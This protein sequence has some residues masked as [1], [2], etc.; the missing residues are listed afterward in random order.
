MN[1][2][3]LV[4]ATAFYSGYVPFAPGTVGS[5]VGVGVY[6]ALAASGVP[7]AVPAA[8]VAVFAAGVWA[9]GRAEAHFRTIDPGPVVI[10]EV[11]GM[12]V[13][14][15][16]MDTGYAGLAAGFVLFRVF[17][18]I[19]PYPANRLERLPGGLGIMADDVMAG[20]YANVALRLLIVVAPG[21]FAA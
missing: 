14:L 11:A 5:V 1:R 8:I 7:W 15:A 3:A 12:L 20:V 13:S 17:D 6:L 10:D 21:W 19:K 2:L 9:A 16:W 4:L 18:I